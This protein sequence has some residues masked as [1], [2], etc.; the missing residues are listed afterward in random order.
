MVQLYL[1]STRETPMSD[2]VILLGDVEVGK[3]A[4]KFIYIYNDSTARLTNIKLII[5]G[6][7]VKGFA[8]GNI[9]DVLEPFAQE[10]VRIM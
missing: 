5:V 3:L 1:D 2:G 8:I 10:R 7:A 9:P 4:E 6:E